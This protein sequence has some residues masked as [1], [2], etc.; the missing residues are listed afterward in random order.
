MVS[1]SHQA[2]P[3]PVWL[4][5]DLGTS[6][7]RAC[8][9][10]ETDTVQAWASAAFA[11]TL[12][13]GTRH[14]QDPADWLQALHHCLAELHTQVPLHRVHRIAVDATSSTV[15]CLNE[16]GQSCGPALMYNDARATRQATALDAIAPPDAAVHS[17]TSSIAKWLWLA[18]NPP[19]PGRLQ[20]LHQADW[21]N[22]QLCAATDVDPGPTFVSDENN[23]LKLGYDPQARQWPDW[24]AGCLA[25]RGLHMTQLPEVVAPGTPLGTIGRQWCED[26]GFDPAAEVVAGTTDS[27]AALMATGAR[28]V[29]D[30]VTV[31]GSTLVLKLISERP[32]NAPQY[33]VYSHRLGDHWLVGGASNAGGACLQQFFTTRQLEALSQQINPDHPSR[34]D[35]YPLPACG[36]RFPIHDPHMPPRCT[37][38]PDDDVRFLQGLLEGLTAI[39]T[40][41]WQRLQEL[42][43]APLKRLRSSGGGSHNPVW[44]ELRRRAM[45]VD[46]PAS[47]HD[48]AAFGSARLAKNGL[49]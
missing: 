5:I 44:T 46:M 34:L 18:D 48:E 14:E 4:G 41:A 21:L 10:D 7:C 11:S 31:L 1:Q 26:Y 38:R 45:G 17:A 3:D 28:H 9:I 30:G 47:D 35:Y 13:D 27:I 25:D 16:D 42:G 22:W 33:G 8:V 37:P 36:E 12:Q 15:V 19:A 6:G 2:R 40:Q 39:E 29:G 23:C 43:A 20:Y 32:L 24:L 49:A